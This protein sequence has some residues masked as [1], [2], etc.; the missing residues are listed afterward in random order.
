MSFTLAASFLAVLIGGVVAEESK[1]ACYPGWSSDTQDYI[2]GAVASFKGNNFIVQEKGW[3]HQAACDANTDKKPCYPTVWQAATN[4]TSL[5]QVSYNGFNYLL[6]TDSWGYVGPCEGLSCVSGTCS[7]PHPPSTKSAT[8]AIPVPTQA[9][10]VPPESP[11]PNPNSLPKMWAGV[12]SYFIYS[13]PPQDQE[14]IL[15]E[16]NKANIKTVRIFLTAFGKGGKGTTSVGSNDLEEHTCGEYDDSILSQ[17]DAMMPLL[18]KYN[19]RLLIAMHDRW[20]LDGTWGT[21][22]AYCQKY[23]GG[24]GKDLN[25]FFSNP[26][27][28]AQFDQRLAHI[29]THKN[30]Y[31]GNRAWS[32]IPEAI[33][34]FEIANEAQGTS[35]QY[36]QFSNPNWWCG[37]ATALRSVIGASSV[38]ISTGGGQNFEMSLGQENFECKALDIVAIHSYSGDMDDIRSN[39]EHAQEQ[40]KK[41]G[42][43]V[44]FEEFGLQSGKGDFIGKVAELCNSMG[45]PWMPWQVSNPTAWSDYEFWTDDKETWSAL[46]KWAKLAV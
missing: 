23:A 5:T 38:L 14:E 1:P 32:D 2:L 46:A 15:S 28:Q 16:L 40:G 35:N 44:I 3:A 6:E 30:P 11:S 42:K 8:V 19:I 18:V 9:P 10:Q 37:R 12:N 29:A 33:Y 26:E 21:C 25:S 24:P 31:M 22:D 41:H 45:I 43:I 17:V 27:A 34:S 4:Y 7:K 36:N 20:N 39:L 13:L